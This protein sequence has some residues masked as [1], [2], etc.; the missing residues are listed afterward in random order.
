[1]SLFY[2]HRSD[3]VEEY[4]EIGDHIYASDMTLQGSYYETFH[5]TFNKTRSYKTGFMHYFDLI[6][7]VFF[8][9]HG[10]DIIAFLIISRVS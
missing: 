3:D 8:V 2:F 6:L 5:Q 9:L 1:M 4:A 10:Q 7:L